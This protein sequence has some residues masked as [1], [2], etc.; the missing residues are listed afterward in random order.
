MFVVFY[1]L[2]V[3]IGTAILM[4]VAL[5]FLKPKLIKTEK[6][7]KKLPFVSVLIAAR[8][9]QENLPE[10]FQSLRVFDYPQDRFELLFGDDQS[11]DETGN[12]IK[13]FCKQYPNATYRCIAPSK[14]QIAKANVLMQL[15]QNAKG[16]LLYFLDADMRPN[17]QILR[18]YVGLFDA[19]IAGVTGVT[20]P[21]GKG[22][23]SEWQKIDWGFTLQLL[24]VVEKLGFDTTAMG[25]NTM[26]RRSDYDAVGGYGNISKSTVEDL[27]LYQAIRKKNRVYT[28][29]FS[30]RLLSKT[31]PEK[32][33]IEL[34]QQRKRW[35]KGGLQT[36]WFLKMV[37]GLQNVFYPLMLVFLVL[38]PVLGMKVWLLKIGVQLVF[39]VLVFRFL[40]Q[41]IKWVSLLSYE[42][43]HTVFTCLLLAF[44][45]F[46]IKMNWKGRVY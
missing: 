5:W 15:A 1:T 14:E 25:N 9:E 6:T 20:L 27:A 39:N 22:V 13:A 40:N 44:Y 16:E 30:D 41:K 3:L 26:V 17:P 11:D 4:L 31:A 21:E 35:M 29:Q 43:Y 34:I 45:F 2:F 24:A 12:L 37:I 46:P 23:F 36:H 7:N 10:L 19:D 8:N 38:F 28:L 42:F 32:S 18:S 33:W